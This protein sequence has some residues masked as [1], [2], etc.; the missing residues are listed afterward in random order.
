VKYYSVEDKK[1]IK[2]ARD[3]LTAL[4]IAI[5]S[6]CRV[7]LNIVRVLKLGKPYTNSYGS[8]EFATTNQVLASVDKLLRAKVLIRR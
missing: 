5:L 4:D 1:A 7:G 6:G 3:K 2:E 8:K